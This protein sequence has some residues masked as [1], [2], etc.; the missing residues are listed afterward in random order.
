MRTAVLVL[1]VLVLVAAVSGFLA[2]AT[3]QTPA[4]TL[5]LR[6]EPAWPGGRVVMPLGPAGEFALHTHRTPVDIVMD[7]R[8]PATDVRLSDG[9]TVIE[10]LQRDAR[11][12]FTSFLAT[13]FPWA[14]LAGAAAGALVAGASGRWRRLLLGAAA[15][16]AVA[17][18]A[19]GALALTTYL[20][21]DRSPAAEYRGLATNVPKVLPLLRVLGSGSAGDHLR[22]LQDYVSGLEQ[23]AVQLDAAPAP[24][25]R[26]GVTRL[27]LVSDTHDNVFGMR[28]AA[29]LAAGG[30]APVDGVL[31]AGDVTDFGL[32]AEARLFARTLAGLDVPVAYV[33]GNHEDAPAMRVLARAGLVPAGGGVVDVAGV[34]VAGADDPLA[35]S[36]RIDSDETLL[37]AGSASL[38]THWAALAP[39]P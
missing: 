33:G 4:G 15:G 19:A 10:G 30:G 1:L 2:A 34:L 22:G 6:V 31:V 36:P 12:A 21:V 5:S 9:G 14:L 28:A 17:A 27:L 7:Y 18:V 11:A 20:T 13:R 32:A 24:P 38:A 37:A 39:R 23:V 29:R 3:Y 26:G 8:L 25:E 16:V 35:R